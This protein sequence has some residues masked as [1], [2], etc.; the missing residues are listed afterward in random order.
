M[1]RRF[2]FSFLFLSFIFLNIYIYIYIYLLKG[3]GGRG[4]NNYIYNP[5]CILYIYI[6]LGHSFFFLSLVKKKFFIYFLKGVTISS[7]HITRS[8]AISITEIEGF[9]I[10]INCNPCGHLIT[11]HVIADQVSY[12][13]GRASHTQLGNLRLRANVNYGVV[14]C[15]YG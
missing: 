3:G 4:E 6:F 2:F 12:L 8:C 5:S 14:V 10:N 15:T 9:L 11:A 7:T 1:G 13:T